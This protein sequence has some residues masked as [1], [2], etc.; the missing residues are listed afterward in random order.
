MRK[1][2]VLHGPNLNLL[3]IREPGIYGTKTLEDVNNALQ[4]RGRNL[5]LT[6]ECFQSN[7][8]GDLVDRIQQAGGRFGGL[9]IN[10]A[11]LTHYSHAISDAI[12]AVDLP[13]IEV[14]LSNIFARER[15]RRRSVISPVASGVITGLGL[16]GYLLG[17]EALAAMIAKNREAAD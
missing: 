15:F 9:I 11:A 1:V 3:G 4:E 2:L 7:H 12:A 6:V 16:Q 17:I 5:G 10:P 8:E 14:H 13:V